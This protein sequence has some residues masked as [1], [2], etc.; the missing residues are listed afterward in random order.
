M[1][2]SSHCLTYTLDNNVSQNFRYRH[3]NTIHTD[4]VDEFEYIPAVNDD[5]LKVIVIYRSP[6]RHVDI[7]FHQIL[8]VGYGFDEFSQPYWI[9]QCSYGK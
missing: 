2:S 4:E 7:S 9:I 1:C 3:R 5:E 8:I 6:R